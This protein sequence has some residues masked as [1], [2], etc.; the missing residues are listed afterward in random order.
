M[1][2][3]EAIKLRELIEKAVESLN[4]NEAVQAKQLYPKWEPNQTYTTGFKFQYNGDLYKCFMDHTSQ[5]NWLPG[6][7]TES[8]YTRI[9]ETHDGS[10]G[11]PIPYNGNMALV[12]GLY[13]EQDGYIYQCIRDTVNPVYNPLKDLIGLYA[14]ILY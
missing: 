5:S 1:K 8:L 10:L 9:D 7:G 3:S 6:V 14:V 11:D 12:N 13:Y 4:D 2:L